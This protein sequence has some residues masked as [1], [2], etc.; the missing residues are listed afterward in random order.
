V[1]AALLVAEDP[2]I[3]SWTSPVCAVQL[4]SLAALARPDAKVRDQES[5]AIRHIG[6]RPDRDVVTVRYFLYWPC[7]TLSWPRPHVIFLT[8]STESLH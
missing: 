7:R 1:L 5:E 2:G 6:A 3:I 8:L 4:N